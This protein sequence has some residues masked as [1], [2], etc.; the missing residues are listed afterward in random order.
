MKISKEIIIGVYKITNTITNKYYIGYTKDIYKRFSGHR[1]TLKNG[2]HQ[3][4]ILQRS[5]NKYTL[6]AFTFEILHQYDNIEDAKNKELEYLQNLEIRESL[7][8]IHY[9]SSGGDILSNHPDRKDIISRITNTLNNNYSKMTDEEK[10]EKHGQPG[11]KNSMFGKTHT[12]EARK[13]ISD[14]NKGISKNL[15]FK[16]SDEMKKKLSDIAKTRTGNK[17]PFYGKGKPGVKNPFYGKKLSDEA[18]KSISEK[19]KGK[20]HVETSKKNYY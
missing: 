12:E 9:N 7:Y 15:G 19:N 13:N 5:Y 6:Q 10:K 18:K 14:K 3:N 17:N 1:N 20:K 16:H 8:N 4:I 11:E 2:H